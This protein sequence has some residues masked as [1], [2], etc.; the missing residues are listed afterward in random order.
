VIDLL[1]ALLA[2]NANAKKLL[3]MVASCA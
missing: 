2:V 3:M 1:R